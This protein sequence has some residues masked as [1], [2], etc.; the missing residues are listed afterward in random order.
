MKKNKQNKKMVW[1]A[2]GKIG[3]VCPKTIGNFGTTKG[4]K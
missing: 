3:N 4:K 2:S 1:G